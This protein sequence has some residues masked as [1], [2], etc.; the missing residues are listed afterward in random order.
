MHK[1]LLLLL[2]IFLYI[3]VHQAL[4]QH[5]AS[6]RARTAASNFL[7]EHILHFPG[8]LSRSFSIQHELQRRINDTLL[9]YIFTT[10]PEGYIIVSAWEGTRPVIGYSFTGTYHEDAQPC[11]FRSWL[12]HYDEEILYLVRNSLSPGDHRKEWE[13]LT[14]GHL[15]SSYFTR[16]REVEPLLASTWN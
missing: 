16:S 7:E 4:G 8:S 10:Y 5:V 6:D 2:S 1:N 13:V 15:S 12:S 3:S 9:S 14:N 11:N